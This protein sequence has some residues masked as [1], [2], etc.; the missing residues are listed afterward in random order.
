MGFKRDSCYGNKKS[1]NPYLS[2]VEDDVQNEHDKN[3]QKLFR[4]KINELATRIND[5][6][7]YLA[8]DILFEE[9][10]HGEKGPK[11]YVVRF[12]IMNNDKFMEIDQGLLV[13]IWDEFLKYTQELR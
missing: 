11:E 13:T 1:K 5:K 2:Y 9:A 7:G 3:F 6:I 4:E 8:V 12:R 10:E